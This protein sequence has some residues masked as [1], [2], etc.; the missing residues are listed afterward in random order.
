MSTAARRPSPSAAASAAGLL[1]LLGG[2]L[3]RRLA[4]VNTSWS[5]RTRGGEPA[6][7]LTPP[8]LALLEAS[9]EFFK[10]EVL[11]RLDPTDLTLFASVG[12]AARSAVV[13]SGLP[14][15]GTT[16]GMPLKVDDFVG[17]VALL[18][19]AKDNGCPWTAETFGAIG[20]GG[21]MAELVWAREH[22]C[23]WDYET[24][25]CATWA[26][27][28]GMLQWAREHGCEWDEMTVRAPATR[29]GHL[30]VLRWAIRE[31][32]CPWNAD[33]V[34][35]SADGGGH[36][37]VMDWLDGLRGGDDDGDPHSHHP[38]YP[39]PVPSLVSGSEAGAYTRPL[40]GST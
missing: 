21:N 19:W 37:A 7:P 14:R 36:L 5:A 4:K 1:S 8:L 29:E 11:E 32:D 6:S 17:S 35:F 15:A 20:E 16:A 2:F 26:G 31:H 39:S 24:C 38:E 25:A 23:P 10:M 34:S 33:D 40:F 30:E 9:P 18:A 13:A 28:M 27:H 22:D 12:K 3:A